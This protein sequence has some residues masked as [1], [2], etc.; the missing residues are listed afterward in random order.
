MG[1]LHE[2]KMP[3]G[4]D[5]AGRNFS[6]W[7]VLELCKM[8]EHDVARFWLCRCE[9]GVERLVNQNNLLSGASRSCGCLQKEIVG[10]LRRSHNKSSHRLYSIW[11]HMKARCYKP[12]H[13]DYRWYGA[14]GI[15]VCKPWFRFDGFL[16]DM[17]KAYSAGMTIERIDVNGNYEPANCRWATRAEQAQNTRR[18]I[19]LDTPWGHITM[20]Q[21]AL[22]V[23]INP[24][25]FRMR[26]KRNWPPEQLYSPERYSRWTKP[27]ER[28]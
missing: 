1:F 17:E 4:M 7:R 21:A 16:A 11:Q 27:G 8:R 13:R 18:V 23:G 24:A 14:R 6:R 2:E 26:V 25:V 28:P 5:L 20:R 10:D 9:C 19:I 12:H 22:K 3:R 15:K